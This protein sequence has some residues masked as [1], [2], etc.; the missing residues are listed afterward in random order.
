MKNI[1]C[2]HLFNDYSGSPKVLRQVIDDLLQH[3]CRVDLITSRGGVLDTLSKNDRLNIRHYDYCFSGRNI[4]TALRYCRIQIY[5]FFLAFKYLFKQ[6]AVFY[7]NTLL[8]AGPALAGKLMGKK[9]V[10][11]YHEN[12]S[13][14]GRSYKM[15]SW[16]MQ[17]TAS[18]I[19]CVSDWQRNSLKRK[20]NV[21]V[22]P[23]VLPQEFRDAFEGI[24]PRTLNGTNTV[25]ML[26]SLKGYKGIYEFIELSRRLP[27]YKFRLVIND[28]KENTRTFLSNLNIEPPTNTEILC[29]QENV[30]PFYREASLVLNL[31]DKEKF[32]ETFGLT[33]LEA[34]T[35]GLP[36]IVPTAGGIADMVEHGMNGYR[37]DI[38]ELDEIERHIDKILSDKELYNKLS[39]NALA[40][41]KL[42]NSRGIKE[43]IFLL[44]KE[45]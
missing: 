45:K 5:T 38:K 12:A 31:S 44:C 32:V 40:Y 2:F 43:I 11:H 1:V 37:I 19:I 35:A 7:I 21:F 34:M 9:V 14:K 28:T 18:E 30:I 6:D 20:K 17:R 10:C 24:D 23:N 33:A 42:H 8:P 27:Q 13:V 41:S 39:S 36:V 15:L 3:G 25:L 4:V 29:R 16:I 22:I 26:S